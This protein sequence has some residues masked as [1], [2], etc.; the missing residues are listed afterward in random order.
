ME[1]ASLS[2]SYLA[3][4]TANLNRQIQKTDSFK[5][6]LEKAAAN[7]NDMELLNACQ[8]FEGYFIQMMY[9][10]MRKTIDTSKSYIQKSNAEEIFQGMLD[11]E[12]AVSAAKKGSGIGLAEMMYKQMKRNFAAEGVSAAQ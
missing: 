9:K 7:Q 6:A 4:Q 1:I 12:V 2:N 5:D 10:E 11:E 3:T 8:E